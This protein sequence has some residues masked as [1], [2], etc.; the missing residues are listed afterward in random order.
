M[1]AIKVFVEV[2]KERGISKAVRAL[3]IAPPVVTRMAA[4]PESHFDASLL[5]R[6]GLRRDE[7]SRAATHPKCGFIARRLAHTKGV[8]CAAPGNLE[9]RGRPLH[10]CDPVQHEAVVPPFSALQQDLVFSSR[11]PSQADR[12]GMAA[13][14]G[15]KTFSL[16]Q[17]W[18]PALAT[19]HRHSLRRRAGGPGHRRAAFACD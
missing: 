2:I 11:P 8:V 3:D 6:T 7:P 19:P 4:E 5:N 16:P 9:G 1:S 15:G 10:P 12:S 18:R 13:T 17:T 14:A